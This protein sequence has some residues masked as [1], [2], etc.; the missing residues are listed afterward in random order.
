M[1]LA[2]KGKAFNIVAGTKDK[3]A[4]A[5]WERIKTAMAPNKA[6]DLIKLNKQF[7]NLEVEDKGEDTDVYIGELE[8]VNELYKSVGSEHKKSGMDMVVQVFS[9]L[10]D[11]PYSNP[12]TSREAIG[13]DKATLEEVKTDLHDYWENG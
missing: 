7:T 13:I 6:K 11:T 9:V 5:A 2:C 1:F 8:K 10:P 12:I 4:H 3:D